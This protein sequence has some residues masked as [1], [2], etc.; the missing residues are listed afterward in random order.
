MK[1]WKGI[2]FIIIVLAATLVSCSKDSIHGDGF[3]HSVGQHKEEG[4]RVELAEKRSVLLLYS[5]GYNSLSSYL[6][7]DI[8]DLQKGWIPG[9]GRNANILLVY[10]HLPIRKNTYS[11]LNSP[12]LTR[13]WKDAD[14]T[15]IRDTLF[16]YP[17]ETH[18]A[19][20]EQLHKVLNDVQTAFPARSYGMIFSSHATGYLP[21]GY[22]TA[23]YSYTYQEK[24]GMMYR[25]GYKAFRTQ[26]VPYYEPQHDPSLPAVKSI[27]QDQVGTYGNY[28][29][30]E[31]EIDDFARA[32]PM[33]MDYI[34]FDACLMGGVEVAYELR[35]KCRYIGF[36]QTEVLAEGFE[37]TTLADHLIGSETP[38]LQAVC[39]DYFH[40]YDIQSGIYKSAT[41]SLV[42]CSKMEPLAEVCHDL[43]DKY[44]M[45]IISLNPE[46]VDLQQYFRG[47]YHWFY[48]LKDIIAKAGA[49]EQEIQKLQDAL[50]E[51]ICYKASTPEFMNSF[52]IKT[53]SGLSMYLQSQGTNELDKYYRTLEWN[54]ATSLVK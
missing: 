37:Y 7:S 51:C 46:N 48:D 45:T 28:I 4:T 35:N 2:L 44:G 18:S 40:Q 17:E 9:S 36:S 41:I 50:D 26:P 15:I 5:A 31:I 47:D 22:Y 43:F 8:K 39:E 12:T 32:L 29:S 1:N 6:E 21:S 3:S 53:Y 23:P 13:L 24:D 20:A 25:G 34:L 52:P 54:K 38:D 27:G 42:D 33:K 14:G 49:T 19:T 11:T 30:Y 16:R 10:S